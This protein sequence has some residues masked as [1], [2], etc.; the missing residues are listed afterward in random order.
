MKAIHAEIGVKV[1]VGA[2]H[3]GY[4]LASYGA[5]YTDPITMKAGE[6]LVL[7]GREDNWRGW[8]WLWCSNQRGKS[9]WVPQ[10]YV[11][12]TEQEGYVASSDYSA[13]ELSMQMGEALLVAQF[14]SGWFWCSDQHG[15]SGWVPAEH[16]L[17]LSNVV[18]DAD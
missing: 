1:P 14:E 16:M 5:A 15:Q 2:T 7:D 8:T 17:I 10:S 13:Q 3:Y 12:G 11:Q 9:G 4:A 6:P 18:M